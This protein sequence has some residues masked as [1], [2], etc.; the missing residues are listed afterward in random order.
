MKG[1][2][3]FAVKLNLIQL[4]IKVGSHQNPVMGLNSEWR[5]WLI[6]LS[7]IVNQ[8]HRGSNIFTDYFL[9]RN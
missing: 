2:N 3:R 7:R 6:E 5:K 4:H 9:E 1:L 8:R